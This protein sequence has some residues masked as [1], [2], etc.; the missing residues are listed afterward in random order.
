MTMCESAVE[1]AALGWFESLGYRIVSG[2]DIAPDGSTPLRQSF[3]DVVLGSLLADAISRI[4]HDLPASTVDDVVRKV[5]RADSPAMAENNRLFHKLLTNGVDVEYT[6]ADGSTR[7]NKAWLF[8][9][10]EPDNNDWAAVN[11]FTVVE[12]N[13]NRRPDIVVFVNGLPLAVIELKDAATET[14]TLNKAFDQLRTYKNEIPSL[15]RFNE[16]LVISDGI[17]ARIGSLTAGWDR[18]LPWRTTDGREVAPRNHAELGVLLQGVFDKR[19]FLDIVRNFAVFEVGGGEVAKKMAGYHQFHAVNKAIEATVRATSATGDQR[20]GVVWHT[21]GSGKSLTMAYYAGKA[22]RHP[23]LAN[24]TIV[25]LTDRNDLDDQLFETFAGCQDLLRQAP[26][27]AESRDDLKEKLR[28]AS[29]GI[30]FTTIQKFLPDPGQSY[31]MLSDRRNIL[32]VADE[33][34]RSQY[35]LNARV[36]QDKATGQPV[37]AY[38]LAKHVRDAL[39]NAS[40]V[41]F[42]G[43]PISEEDRDTRRVFG[44]YIDVYDIHRAIED[45]ATVPIYYSARL[46]RVDLDE[47]VRAV[48][49]DEFEE[50]TEDEEQE[51]KER[52][53]TRWARMEALVGAEDRVR[54]VA[55]DIVAHFEGRLAPL[56]GKGMVVCM[57]RR[58]CVELHDAIIALRPDWASAKDD[59]DEGKA[60]AVKVVMTGSA[61]DTE[62]QQH[63]RSKERRKK[64]AERFK[65][66]QDP[67]KLVIVRD[68]WLTGF[69]APCLHTMYV[70]KPMHGHGLM[71]AI[72]RV[73]RVFRDKPGG[74]VVD[75]L[76]IGDQLKKALVEYGRQDRADVGV[77][78]ED[79]VA[80]MKAKFEVVAGLYHG[81]DYKRF[82]T[83]TP[84]QQ[85]DLIKGA[86]EHLLQ[87]E[88][89]KK[90]YLQAVAELS[91]AFAL[92]MPHEAAVAIRDDVAFFQAVRAALVKR[93]ITEAGDT[94]DVETAIRQIV[95]K[96]ITSDRVIDVFADAGLDKPDISVLSD[97]FLAEVA[98]MPQRNLALEALRKLLNDEIKVRERKNIVQARNFSEMLEDAIRRYQ[99]RAIDTAEVIQELIELAKEMR[100]AAER[101]VELGLSE[102]ELAFYDAL[103][104]NESAMDVLGN[105]TL[106][107]LAREIVD[108]IR[109][110]VAVDWTEKESVKAN[111]RRLVKRVLRKYGYPPD[112]QEIATLTVL[113]Q[114]ETL[115][116]DWVG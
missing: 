115:C 4:N 49:D 77:P 70:D 43:T 100:E 68:M 103:A 67:F 104:A 31:P 12:N 41:A 44:D 110:T 39:P 64:L 26:V 92:S 19:R 74:L 34:H 10:A 13:R 46:V 113:R 65:E 48:L 108:I 87:T 35:G 23:A 109:R 79:A 80:A 71:Q 69:D 28:V 91:R 89:G 86:A 97:E 81:F 47:D 107:V 85:L 21:Q 6:A 32:F 27:Q 11:Q 33:A 17:E 57:S 7:H 60:F 5:V 78:V 40:F 105:D 96:A 29:G 51:D 9:F 73:N 1:S 98:G 58:I 52:L 54:Q 62:W 76:G 75:Y 14:A 88:D 83:A 20:V 37:V 45:G 94:A 95:S 93:T 38:G 15:F 3:T 72:A 42:T 56:D 61:S 53:K 30:V 2:P 114:A 16:T 84:A 82:F 36:R 66:P 90:R 63:I 24:P 102:E 101:G 50:A 55:K 99:N 111:L 22:A 116:R 18:F 59:N 8:D 25:V 106:R 112:M